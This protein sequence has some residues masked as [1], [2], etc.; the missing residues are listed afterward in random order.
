[1]THGVARIKLGLADQLSLGNLDARRDWGYAGDYVRAM[2]LMLQQDTPEDYVVCTG[3]TYSVRELCQVA[4][5]HAGLNWEDYVVV[6]LRFVRPAEVD[7]LVGDA[8]KAKK[9]LNWKPKVSFEEL[10]AMMVDADL[11]ALQAEATSL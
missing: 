8:S 7:L 11:K 9:V 1:V 2:W 6:D 5:G 4:F 3:R 10:I